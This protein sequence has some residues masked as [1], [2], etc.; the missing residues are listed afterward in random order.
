M[1]AVLPA[2]FKALGRLL[3]LLAGFALA[4]C[5]PMPGGN[6]GQSIN[7]SDPVPVALLV[8]GASTT[9]GD[10]LLADS[11]EKAA[12]L[13][14]GDL[15]GAEIDLR[16]YQTNG[17][18]ESGSAAAVQA[19]TD[20]AKIILGPVFAE[21]A[22][23]A[24][25]AV[26]SRNVN[27]LS[28]SNNAQ[29]AGG[30]VFVLGNTFRNTATRLLSY[31]AAQGRNDVLLVHA[32]N[33]S[34]EAARVAV[35]T[36]ASRTGTRIAAVESYV[37]D[38]QEVINAVPRIASAARSSGANAIFLTSDTAG[39]L[40]LFAQLLPENGVNPTTYRYLGLTRWDLP[41]ETLALPGLQ[42]GWFALPDPALSQQ[43]D[44][45]Y[46]A[47]YGAQP[48][49]IAGLAYDGIA[50]IGALV[51]AGQRNALTTAGLTQ[52]S[53][54]VGVNGVFRFL[55]DGTNERALAIAEVRGNQRVVIDP[56]PRSFG[57]PGF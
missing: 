1:I 11:L 30:N 18:P 39:A 21:E 2:H 50:A 16:V 4:A 26:A 51:S 17:T 41:P 7:T 37:F 54:F 56:A 57:G 25:N 36:A 53:G 10:A 28:F 49:P 13:A 23:A 32:Q 29:I 24:G 52:S 5:A 40:P 14:I 9:R 38:S 46:A 27:V 42:G 19:V 48:H 43:F 20:G 3:L 45:R 33:V 35:T 44:A 15:Q 31:A 22:N 55:P 12:R 6:S 47:A 8:P 34:G